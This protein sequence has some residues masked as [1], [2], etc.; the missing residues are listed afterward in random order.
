MR[1]ATV[2]V[3]VKCVL[4]YIPYYVWAIQLLFQMLMH[5]VCVWLPFILSVFNSV[6][7]SLSSS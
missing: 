5:L 2:V 6:C 7:L 1:G 4:M 3:I